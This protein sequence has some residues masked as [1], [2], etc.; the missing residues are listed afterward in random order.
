MHSV[1]SAPICIISSYLGLGSFFN[2][3]WNI[4]LYMWFSSSVTILLS[5]YESVPYYRY[6]A[7][8]Y[9]RQQNQAYNKTWPQFIHVLS[10]NIWSINNHNLHCHETI[11]VSNCQTRDNVQLLRSHKMLKELLKIKI[12]WEN[13]FY[14]F[15]LFL[16]Q[17]NRNLFYLTFNQ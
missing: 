8:Y 16:S 1:V 4:S 13:V 7:I 17:Y 15:F 2:H 5:T 9:V 6:Y 10:G 11:S 12:E 3:I 14:H